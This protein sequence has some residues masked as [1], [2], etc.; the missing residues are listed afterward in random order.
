MIRYQLE[1]YMDCIGEMAKMYPDHYEELSVTKEFELSPN[2][3]RYRRIEEAGILKTITCRSDEELVGYILA[4]VIPNLHYKT[5]MM[6]VE[7][8]YYLRKDYRKGR[9]GINMFKFFEAEMR[10]LGVN[11]IMLTTKV[12]QDNSKLF[13]YLGY[14]FIEKTF[15]K[16]L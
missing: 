7:D 4:M 9:I 11:R 3:D 2:Y 13:E 1:S 14:S 12:H 15:S 16:V 10:K 5:C 6:A 8:I